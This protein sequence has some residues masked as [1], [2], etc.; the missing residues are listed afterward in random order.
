MVGLEGQG[1]KISSKPTYKR[2]LESIVNKEVK[3]L[4]PIEQSHET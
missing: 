1:N 3:T 4:N 2:R